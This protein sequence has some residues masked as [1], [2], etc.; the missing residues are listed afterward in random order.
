MI[1]MLAIW[2]MCGMSFNV[3]HSYIVYLL[4]A[5][6]EVI[7]TTTTTAV[8]RVMNRVTNHIRPITFTPAPVI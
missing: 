4:Q 6:A 5:K 2:Q 3:D 1:I 7:H 8:A